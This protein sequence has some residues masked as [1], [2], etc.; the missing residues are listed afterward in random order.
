MKTFKVAVVVMRA[1]A[2]QLFFGALIDLTYL[3]A[4]LYRAQVSTL[5]AIE[6]RTLGARIA[7]NVAA[8]AA[9][10]F[11]AAPLSRVLLADVARDALA[12]P[13]DTPEER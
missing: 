5:V 12:A 11:W 3:P 4:Y 13:G 1:L 9:L 2:L 8:G 7:L 10:W 6:I